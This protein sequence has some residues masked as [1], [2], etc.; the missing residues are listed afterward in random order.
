MSH[1]FSFLLFCDS[2]V[3][4]STTA[5]T[6]GFGVPDWQVFWDFGTGEPVLVPCF[7][8]PI[9]SHARTQKSDAVQIAEADRNPGVQA[10]GSDRSKG[11]AV[12]QE[13]SQSIGQGGDGDGDGSL[14]V[15]VGQP[16]GDAVQHPGLLP[17]RDHD[18]HVIQPNSFEREVKGFKTVTLEYKA[19]LA[20]K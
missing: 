8:L 10:E 16:V 11:R 9:Q 18:E 1:G 13:E 14:L 7:P 19:D 3:P 17:A 6:E 15:R 12:A 2:I 5:D 20:G 4:P